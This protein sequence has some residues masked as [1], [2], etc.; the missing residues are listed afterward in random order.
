M[1]GLASACHELFIPDLRPAGPPRST[2]LRMD[3]RTFGH[4]RI[5]LRLRLHPAPCTRD[6]LAELRFL[7]RRSTSNHAIT[8]L[9]LLCLSPSS[10]KW[11]RLADTTPLRL[12]VVRTLCLTI[13]TAFVSRVV[14]G[15]SFKVHPCFRRT[16]TMKAV[17]PL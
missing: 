11:T 7:D 6:Y 8:K 2:P 3:R 13:P 10:E 14:Y 17:V 16:R 12:D 1:K 15:T 4:A 5:P 9:N